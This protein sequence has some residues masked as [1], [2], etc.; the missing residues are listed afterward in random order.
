VALSAERRRRLDL[1]E[2]GYGRLHGWYV[3]K[4]GRRWACL[5]YE[6]WTEMFWDTYVIEALVESESERQRLFSA[7][8]W[9]D[10]AIVYRNRVTGEVAPY[11]FSAQSASPT[12]DFPKIAMRALYISVEL[13][14]L[15]ELLLWFR[16][17]HRRWRAWR[18]TP[19]TMVP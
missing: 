6:C 19:R 7:A 13:G 5:E 9:L 12:E 11:A 14:K 15:D 4:D 2:S 16:R 1:V 18:D 17:C 10:P 3:E 8:F